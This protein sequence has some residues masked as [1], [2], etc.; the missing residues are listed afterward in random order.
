MLIRDECFAGCSRTLL[1]VNMIFIFIAEVF[2]RRKNRVWSCLS[3]TAHGAVLDLSCQFFQEFDVAIFSLAFC[4]SFQDLQHSLGPDT[5]V[6][7]L[8]AGFVS[9]KVQEVSCHIY[10]A[11]ILIHYDH[12]AGSYDSTCLVDIFVRYRRVDQLSR[13]TSAGRIRPSEQP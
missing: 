12:T 1:V 7:A 5:T 11:S 10:H 13:D 6:V 3:E 8:S 2:Q 4:D 9:R